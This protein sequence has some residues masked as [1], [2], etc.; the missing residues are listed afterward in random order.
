MVKSERQD[1]ALIALL[2]TATR[3]EASEQA[4][5]SERTLYK[6]LNDTG[7]KTAY[8]A[9]CNDLMT[10]STAEIQKAVKKAV[11]TLIEAMDNDNVFA[12]ISAS[13][14]LLDYGLKYTEI[15]DFEDRL[16]KLEEERGNK[17]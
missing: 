15:V 12:R 13:K 14:A 11:T 9:A 6:Y 5:I 3:K 17:A 7:F 2:T 1:R 4:G 8:R 16:R 10:E